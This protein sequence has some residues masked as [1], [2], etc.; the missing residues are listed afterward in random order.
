MTQHIMV[1][2]DSH[3]VR[4]ILETALTRVGYTV[5]TFPDGVKAANALLYRQ[6]PIPDVVIVD[7][8]LPFRD[9]YEVI[10]RLRCRSELAHTVFLVLSRRDSVI[11]KLKSRLAG[12]K[13]HLTKPFK[14]GELIKT[15]QDAIIQRHATPSPE[16]PEVHTAL[17]E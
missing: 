8:M 11:D 2:D 17:Y 10:A 3:T 13:D 9:G 7:L 5:T 4:K 15:V 6:T 16:T 1:I 14:V 12:A